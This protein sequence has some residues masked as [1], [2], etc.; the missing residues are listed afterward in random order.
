MVSTSG[1][2][3]FMTITDLNSSLVIPAN[4]VIPN[5]KDPVSLALAS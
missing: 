3:T 4:W 1:Y 5:L 2:L